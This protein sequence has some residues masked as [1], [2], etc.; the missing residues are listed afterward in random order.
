L[1][2][3]T[4]DQ[5]PCIIRLATPASTVRAITTTRAVEPT[6]WGRRE[7]AMNDMNDK[8]QPTQTNKRLLIKRDTLRQLGPDM[9]PGQPVISLLACTTTTTTSGQCSD[10]PA[11]GRPCC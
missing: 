6:W 4:N 10:T 5:A 9:N 3:L 8:T 1:G 11:S 2:R 7:E